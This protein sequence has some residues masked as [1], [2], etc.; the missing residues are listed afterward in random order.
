MLQYDCIRAGC[1]NRTCDV[2]SCGVNY[3]DVSAKG[4]IYTETLT[5]AANDRPLMKRFTIRGEDGT[6]NMVFTSKAFNITPLEN[7]EYVAMCIRIEHLLFKILIRFE[8]KGTAKLF[9]CYVYNND[10]LDR[11]IPL[12]IPNLWQHLF[13]YPAAA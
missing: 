9:R 1:G 12:N 11:D 13:P 5:R 3:H 2:R 10:D 4:T 6:T 7:Y 8:D